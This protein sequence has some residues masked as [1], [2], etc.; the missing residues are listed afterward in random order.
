MWIKG[1]RIKMSID[2]VESILWRWRL[3]FDYKIL[4]VKNDEDNITCYKRIGKME[5]KEI[6]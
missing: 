5:Y 1:M 3:L 4:W 6:D 2:F